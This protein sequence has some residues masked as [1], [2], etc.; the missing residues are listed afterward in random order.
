VVVDESRSEGR[1][2]GKVKVEKGKVGGGGDKRGKD[3]LS[4]NREHEQK[5]ILLLRPLATQFC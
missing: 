1:G 2:E 4:E 5:R 3:M